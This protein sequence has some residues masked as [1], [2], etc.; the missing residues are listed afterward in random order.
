MRLLY[1]LAKVLFHRLSWFENRRLSNVLGLGIRGNSMARVS[2][3]PPS[4]VDVPEDL[5]VPSSGYRWQVFLVLFSLFLFF[6]IYLG[7]LIGSAFLVFKCL[8]MT[9]QRANDLML[10]RIGGMALGLLLFLFLLKGFFKFDRAEKSFDVEVFE[11]DHPRLFDFIDRL[12]EETGADFPARVFINFEVNAMASHDISFLR[13]FVPSKKYL[14]LGLGLVNVLNLTEFK[15]LL[16]H[17][18]GHFSQKSMKIGGYVYMAHRIVGDL[19]YGRDWLDDFIAAWC[20]F[21]LRISFPAWIFFGILWTLRQLLRGLHHAIF[22]LDRGRSRQMEFNADLVAVSVAGSDAPIHLLC[23]CALGDATLNQAIRELQ[24]AM[25]HHLYT[26]DLFYH[27]TKAIPFVRKSM[28]DPNFG[29][30]PPLP[31]NPRKSTQVFEFDDDTNGHQAQMWATH[32]SNYD[33]EENAKA[34]YIRSEFDER[35]PWLLFDNADELKERVTFKFYRVI[36]KVP[37]DAVLA[38]PEEIQGFLDEERA[39]TTFDPRYQG[40]YDLRDVEP[41]S[42]ADLI[43]EAKLSPWPISRLME[44]HAGLYNIEVKHQAQLHNKRL[45]EFN[46]LVAIS[47]GWH[48]PKNDEIDFRGKFYDMEEAKRLIKK[49]EKELKQ[50]QEWFKEVDRNVFLCHYQMALHLDPN[51]AEE[52]KNRYRFHLELQKLWRNLKA[53]EAPVDAAWNF[54][55]S[56]TQHLQREQFKEALDIFRDAHGALGE[57]LRTARDMVIPALKNMTPGEPLAPFL[58]KG[59]LVHGLSAHEDTLRL[60]WIYK[61]MG[62][63]REVQGKVNRIHFKSLGGILALQEKIAADCTRMWSALPQAP[64]GN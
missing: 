58:L 18:F 40:L 42:P 31:E 34:D 6:V 61:L 9:G 44:T 7:L 15:A 8:T 48:R 17:E 45:E 11:E 53:H 35:S 12:C 4:P 51:L 47:N 22:F 39:E 19:V 10:L 16:A 38:E 63:M 14:T 2:Y 24:T 41:G 55:Q 21:D 46:M 52:L 60:K 62:Q 36:F 32:P 50:D 27:Q 3:Y 64:A 26:R 30:P 43:A 28:K 59:K 13:L 37:K 54:L 5:T 56:Q 20:R 1:S 29:E 25:D 57:N 33:R 49:V 23:R